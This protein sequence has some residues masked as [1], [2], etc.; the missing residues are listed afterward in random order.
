MNSKG[1]IALF[2]LMLGLVVLILALAIAPPVNTSIQEARNSTGL[3]CDNSSISKFDK[4]ACIGSDLTQFYF[5][6]SLI[7]IATLIITARIIF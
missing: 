5:I 2:A 7:L 4:A 1:S 6:G 3:D